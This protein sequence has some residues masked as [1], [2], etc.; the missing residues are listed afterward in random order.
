MRGFVLVVD[1]VRNRRES[2]GMVCEK[3][4]IW[5]GDESREMQC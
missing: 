2:R 3:W 4:D 5:M 1:W